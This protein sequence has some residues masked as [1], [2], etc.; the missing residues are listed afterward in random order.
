[1]K[2]SRKNQGFTLIEMLVVIAIIAVLVA[3][4]IPVVAS[5]TTKAKAAT[6]AANLRSVLGEATTLVLTSNSD[7]SVLLT[8][9]IT[10]PACKSFD[11]ATMAIMSSK[12]AGLSIYYVVNDVL[13]YGID[14][15]A[16]VAETGSSDKGRDKS[17]MEKGQ[18]DI[19][20]YT[21]TADGVQLAGGIG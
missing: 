3:I 18:S 11:G 12:P 17:T 2:K 13:Y 1:M 14:Y 5:S 7:D 19:V 10:A 20:W 15:F 9:G 16:E 6:D 8:S 21:V 4:I